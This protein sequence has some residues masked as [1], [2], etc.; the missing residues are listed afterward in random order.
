M[1]NKRSIFQT[2]SRVASTEGPGPAISRPPSLSEQSALPTLPTSDPEKAINEQIVEAQAPK[3]V[4]LVDWDGPD[5]PEKPINW[6]PRKKWTNLALISALTLLTPFGSTMFAPGVPQMMRDFHSDSPDLA[7]FAVSIYILGYALG[8]LFIA[9]LSELYGRVPVYHTCTFVFM[10][11]TLAC[12]LSTSLGM[13]IFM[14]FVAGLAG[15]CPITIGSGTVADCWKQEERGTVM[16]AWTLP[17]L[18]G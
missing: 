8:P 4:N 2:L 1:E 7:S 3:D 13:I 16:S 18:L 10:V 9:P 5:D 15:S 12:G 6:P 17:I 14:R 11:F